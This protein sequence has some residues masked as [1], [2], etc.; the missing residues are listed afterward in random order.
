MSGSS[1]WTTPRAAKEAKFEVRSSASSSDDR[2]SQKTL[3]D[4]PK[5]AAPYDRTHESWLAMTLRCWF[6]ALLAASRSSS[7]M[8]Q[9]RQR[10]KRQRGRQKVCTSGSSGDQELE[11]I[12]VRHGRRWRQ[13]YRS[14]RHQ[15]S[16]R[17]R[18]LKSWPSPWLCGW[19]E[20]FASR[21]PCP[22]F[23]LTCP[24][25]RDTIFPAA[26]CFSAKRA[27]YPVMTAAPFADTMPRVRTPTPPYS[28][29]TGMRAT[30]LSVWWMCRTT[31]SIHAK[32]TAC[33]LSTW[34]TSWRTYKS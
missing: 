29:V 25:H 33:K 28:G 15:S 34:I 1:G 9:L 10:A 7:N 8:P 16:L 32:S 30:A 20:W 21:G 3:G 2:R 5:G 12:T 26:F 19:H 24:A 23:Q 22:C 11:K 6:E 4:S 31:C 13:K 27:P 14:V 17:R 18:S